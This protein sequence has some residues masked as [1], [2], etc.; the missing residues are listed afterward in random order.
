[1]TSRATQMNT[2]AAFRI[3]FI[4]DNLADMELA[5]RAMR[6]ERMNFASRCEHDAGGVERALVEFVPDVIIAAYSMAEF[7]GLSALRLCRKMLPGAPF[8]LHTA[9]LSDEAAAICLRAGADDYVLK[10]NIAHLPFVIRTLIGRRN[11][12]LEKRAVEGRLGMLSRAVEQ[13]PVSII[14]SDMS[15]AIEYVNPKFLQ[16]TGYTMDEV[17][18]QNPRIL[19]SGKQSPEFYDGLWKTITSGEEWRGEIENRKK[20]GESFWEF[21]SISPIRDDRG[22]I[23]HFLAVKEDITL[24][25]ATE[26]QLRKSNVQIQEALSRAGELADK[27]EAANRAK[28]EFL[29]NMSHEIR[30]PMNGVIGMTGLLLETG[31]NQEQRE[32]AEAIQS[33]GDSLLTLINDI[34]DFSK[35]EAGQLV[36]ESLDFDL[37]T[38]LEDAVEILAIKAQEKGLDIVCIVDEHAPEYLRGD[39]GVHDG[40]IIKKRHEGDFS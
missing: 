28:S 26:E 39:P 35:V 2:G 10:Q 32:Y 34:L 12:V 31:L 29:A 18:G 14:I 33:C 1:M 30:T 5:E 15:G 21:A 3:L 37:R 4:E 11:A 13:S 40:R 7:D 17:I 23:T 16:V 20:N 22:V 36:L 6:V 8:I 25:K 27:A 38:T 9:E 19:K 24:R